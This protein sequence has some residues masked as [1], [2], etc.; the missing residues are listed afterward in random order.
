MKFAVRG[1]PCINVMCGSFALPLVREMKVASSERHKLSV[2]TVCPD[3][4][5]RCFVPM[6]ELTRRDVDADWLAKR[7]PIRNS[8]RQIC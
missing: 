2:E 6:H 4:G 5:R 8:L 7:F 1:H 3:C